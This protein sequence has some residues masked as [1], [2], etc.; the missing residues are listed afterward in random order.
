[1]R[2]ESHVIVEKP[3][4]NS[5]TWR[6]YGER[7]IS[8]SPHPRFLHIHNSNFHIYIFHSFQI[9]NNNLVTTH[10]YLEF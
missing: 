10:S 2:F 7:P 6:K 3:K 5:W 4:E 9:K 8:G 1:M